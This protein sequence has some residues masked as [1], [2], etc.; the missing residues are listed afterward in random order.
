MRWS[1]VLDAINITSNAANI[2]KYTEAWRKAKADLEPAVRV[3][4]QFGLVFD[5]GSKLLVG[6]WGVVVSFDVRCW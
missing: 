2:A 4:Q 1:D 3:A 5:R 6:D